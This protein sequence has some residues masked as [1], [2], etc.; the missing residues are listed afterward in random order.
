MYGTDVVLITGYKQAEM[1][2]ITIIKASGRV[3]SLNVKEADLKPIKL[4]DTEKVLRKLQPNKVTPFECTFSD[5]DELNKVN[6]AFCNNYC[7]VI[8]D[9]IAIYTDTIFDLHVLQN[10]LRELFGITLCIT[11]KK[12]SKPPIK[13]IL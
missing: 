6:I 7:H 12:E 9:G 10:I 8:K 4:D 13:C 2:P 1:Y 3:E 11:P 5:E